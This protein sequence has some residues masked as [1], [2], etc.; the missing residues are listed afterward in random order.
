M[1]ELNYAE[2]LSILRLNQ[3][4]RWTLREIAE[5]HDLTVEE[6]R[7]ALRSPMPSLVADPQPAR[8]GKG[9]ET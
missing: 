2:R 7:A 3:S 1:R 4:G 8:I 9:G 6:V 5:R